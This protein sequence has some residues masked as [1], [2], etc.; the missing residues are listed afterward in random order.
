VEAAAVHDPIDDS[1]TDALE[2]AAAWLKAASSVTVLTGAGVSAESGLATFRAADGLWEGH[3]VED[4]ATPEAFRRDPVLVWK[5]YNLRRANLH[6]AKPNPGHLALAALES[7]FG[8]KFALATQNVDRLHQAGGSRRVL[9]LHGNLHVVRCSACGENEDR[10]TE[11]LDELPKCKCGGLLRPGVVWFHEPLP[12]DVWQE[13]AR[14]ACA[15]DVFLVIGTSAVVY[16]AAGLIGAARSSGAKTI[17]INLQAT[18]ASGS[19][20]LSLYGPSGQILPEL[21]KRSV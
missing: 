10:G 15:C 12:E 11:P 16:P 18:E 5:F 9:E 19:V 20:D 13:A 1:P 6:V 7:R 3:R 4:V 8:D 14:A 2:R 21:V 17:E